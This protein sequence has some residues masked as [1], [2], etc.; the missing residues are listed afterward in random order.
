MAPNMYE[1]L[2]RVVDED[3]SSVFA[4]YQGKAFLFWGV[5]DTATPLTA[6]EKMASLIAGST[7]VPLSG[8]HFFFLAHNREIAEKIENFQ[9]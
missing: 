7:F 2:K 5:D 3:F 9:K 1:T 4:S 8:D 6:G